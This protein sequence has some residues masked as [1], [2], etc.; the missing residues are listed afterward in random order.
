[1]GVTKRAI[2]DELR[3]LRNELTSEFVRAAGGIACGLLADRQEYARATTLLAYV[4]A[5]QEVPTEPLI[6]DAQRRGMRVFLPRVEGRTMIFGEYRPGQPLRPNRL[7]IG[8]PV[9]GETWSPGAEET[10]VCLPLV[11]WDRSGTRLGRGGGYY[12]RFFERRSR[13]ACL[14]GLG[15]AFQER[16][17]LPRD[18]WDVPLDL[19]VTEREVVPCLATTR[20]A[21]FTKGGNEP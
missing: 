15:Y 16:P 1:M 18:P 14:V 17:G 4:A 8:E 11:A 7:G 12:D 19:V 3:Q 13:G 21:H 2:R 10:L 5:D 6:G 9:G 20:H